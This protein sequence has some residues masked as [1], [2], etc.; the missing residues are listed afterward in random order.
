MAHFPH[1][2][3]KTLFWKNLALPS[4]PPD[5]P[6][7]SC[8]V[9]EKNKPIP[10]KLLEGLTLIHRTLSAIPINGHKILHITD[11][12]TRFSTATIV[13]SK[14]KE[15]IVRAIGLHYLHPP[16]EIL[17]DNGGKFINHLVKEIIN[18][19]KIF[20]KSSAVESPWSNDITERHINILGN[21]INKLL[22]DKSNNYVV[23]IIAVWAASAKNV[24]HNLYGY[25]LKQ[26]VFRKNPDYLCFDWPFPCIRRTDN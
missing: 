2:W 5:G 17:T 7:T 24:L 9:S 1:F 23:E 14:Q 15:E 13:K 6:L 21:T 8:K 26:L 16:N 10:R 12:A 4:T 3:G 19:L 11:Y 22:L 25:S 18:Y 20:I